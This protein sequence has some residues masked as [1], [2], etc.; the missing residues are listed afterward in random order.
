MSVAPLPPAPT[1][2]RFDP[3]LFTASQW[4]TAEQK[5][6]FA[7]HYTRFV[8]KGFPW[9]LFPEWFY[10]RL[11]NCYMHIAHFNRQGFAD[12]WFSTPRRRSE[13]L[14]H[15]LGYPCYGSPEYTYSDVERVLKAWIRTNRVDEY[16]R[17][18]ADEAERADERALL[19]TLLERH[20]DI[21]QPEPSAPLPPQVEFDLFAA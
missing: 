17:A 18:I 5:A 13:F 4:D 16:Y 14:E 20:P 6:R 1:P 9:T 7:N 10:K 12:V 21:L 19:K 11:S 15:A 8:A 3:S 2:R